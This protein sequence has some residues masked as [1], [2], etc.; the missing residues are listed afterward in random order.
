MGFTDEWFKLT[1][2]QLAMEA[3]DWASPAAEGWSMDQ[4]K[5]Q[6]WA[7]LNVPGDQGR[8]FNGTG[9]FQGVADVRDDVV[10]GV[11]VCPGGRWRDGGAS[12]VNAT[13]SAEYSDLGHGPLLTV[14]VDV[15][16]GA[17]G[18]T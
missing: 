8:V 11:I 5:E 10:S 14:P 7:R 4:L 2:E 16:R 17:R 1:D 15:E 18:R 3:V 13:V 9:S 12:T 6:G